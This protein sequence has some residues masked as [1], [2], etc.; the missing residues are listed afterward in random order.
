[1]TKLNLSR[2]YEVFQCLRC[3]KRFNS[4]IN[5]FCD[6]MFENSLV[7]KFDADNHTLHL[8]FSMIKADL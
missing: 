1:M 5:Q 6:L 4:A 3:V 2:F 8:L 7:S